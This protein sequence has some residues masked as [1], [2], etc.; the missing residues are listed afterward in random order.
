MKRV[1]WLAPLAL[2]FAMPQVQ[3]AEVKI[4][5]VT[6]LTGPAAVIGN[7][8]R[9]AAEL[10]LEHIN[11]KM[12]PLDVSIIYADDEQNPQKGKQAVE[13]LVERDNVDIVTG[14]I[15]SNVLLASKDV[16]LDANKF[17]ISA[18]AGPSDLAGKACHKN[19]FNISW[20]ND[21]TP[22]ALGELLNQR[23]VKS[24]YLIA[25]NY[26]AGQDMV[27]GVERTFKG[28]VVGKDMTAWPAQMDWSA[29]LTKVKASGAEGVFTFYPGGH[30]PAFLTQYDQAGLT[31]KTPLY[32]VYT[33]DAL[34]LPLLQKAGNK[35]VLGT[36]LTQMWA[37]DM[38]N[39]AN[40]KF[41]GDFKK[42]HNAYPSY[43]AAQAYDSI[44]LIKSAVEAVKGNLKDMDG[45]RKAMEAAKFDSVRGPFKMG[46]NHFPIQN[47]YANEVVAD[48]DGMWMNSLRQVVLKDHQD[49]YAK[50]CKM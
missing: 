15:W 19:F 50:D 9:N 8:F 30:G 33:V 1:F 37:A 20:Q 25:P 42:K 6:T 5:F 48:K 21:Q 3:A 49:A 24:L 2:A 44:M 29:E 16:V 13:K 46:P 18:N 10:A 40:K 17:L 45:M 34:S 38:D 32:S 12:G 27:A 28:K 7:E 22:M 43:Y 26:A 39:A 11:K 4:G 14:Q 31:G 47:F 35:A 23:G 36:Y 41:V